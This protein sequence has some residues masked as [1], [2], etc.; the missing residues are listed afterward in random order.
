VTVPPTLAQ[1]VRT[2]RRSAR[3]ALWRYQGWRQPSSRLIRRFGRARPD[4]TFVQVGSNDGEQLDP[5]RRSILRLRW[6]GLMIEPV[7]HVFARLE[8]NYADVADRVALANV[9]IADHEGVVPFHHLAE[10]EDHE[11][12][13]LPRW[14]DALGS[15]RR[16]IVLKHTDLIPDLEERLVTTPVVCTTLERVCQE[17]G[18][19]HIDLLHIDTEGY[20]LE[21]LRNVDWDRQRPTI[22]LYEHLHLTDGERAEAHRLL[23]GLGYGCIEEHMD[24]ICVDLSADDPRLAPLRS[25]FQ[26]LHDAHTAPAGR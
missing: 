21:V 26:R 24:T 19:E 10:V 16:E 1:Q 14:Y 17:H 4:A 7:P 23:E 2:L 20:D 8:Q 22:V 25:R 18:I 9:A 5:L 11:A 12:E 3:R 15:F 13:G 6:R